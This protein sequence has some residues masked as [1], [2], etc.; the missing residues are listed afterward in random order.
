MN[1]GEDPDGN[2]KRRQRERKPTGGTGD[3]GDTGEFGEAVYT[4]GQPP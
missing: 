2:G 3:G 1:G 4:G